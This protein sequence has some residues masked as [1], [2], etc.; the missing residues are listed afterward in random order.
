MKVKH[1][2]EAPV[3][4]LTVRQVGE[5]LGV[6]PSTVRFWIRTGLLPAV[7]AGRRVLIHEHDLRRFLVPATAPLNVKQKRK[8][9]GAQAGG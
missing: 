8:R 7:R 9:V 4:C 1:A 2:G 6:P 5:A 3:R